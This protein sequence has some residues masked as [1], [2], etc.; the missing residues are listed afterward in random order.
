VLPGLF[1][2]GRPLACAV[3]GLADG[4]RALHGV[5]LARAGLL[6]TGPGKLLLDPREALEPRRAPS[7]E[8]AGPD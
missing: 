3:S 7:L 2:E 8:F 5:R 4:G 6:A 1:G